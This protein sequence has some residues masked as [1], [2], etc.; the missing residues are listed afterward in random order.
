MHG[1]VRFLLDIQAISWVSLWYNII[2]GPIYITNQSYVSHTSYNIKVT[3]TRLWH[4]QLIKIFSCDFVVQ[5]LRVTTSYAGLV[6]M[7]TFFLERAVTS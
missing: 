3:I 2:M 1:W 4:T 5:T 6:S 7:T